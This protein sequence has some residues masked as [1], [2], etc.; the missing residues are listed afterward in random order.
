MGIDLESVVKKLE[1]N[2]EFFHARFLS[3]EPR[4]EL[5]VFDSTFLFV[6]ADE[7][8]VLA[9]ARHFRDAREESPIPPIEG[10]WLQSRSGEPK[11]ESG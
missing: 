1:G 11:T 8:T 5:G 7:E 3:I 2:E 10:R 6:N 9:C 4:V